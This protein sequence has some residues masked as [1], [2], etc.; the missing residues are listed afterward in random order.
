MDA[1]TLRRAGADALAFLLPIQCA[2]CG[3]P[4]V[5]LCED[6]AAAV[7]PRPLER[8]V[9]GVRVVSGLV[10]EDRVARIVRVLK[11]EGR[12]SLARALAP[13]LAAAARRFDDVEFTVVPVPTSAAAMR[14][15]GY[16]VAELLARRAGWH[17]QRLLRVVRRT[18]DQRALGR[19]ERQGNVAESMRSRGAAAGRSILLVDDVVTTGAT[20][21]EAMRALRAAGAEVVGAVTVAATPRRVPTRT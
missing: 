12:T 9:D 7:R 14:R 4:D 10:F 8:D 16:R 21:G 2:G 18:T 1:E 6:C 17:P 19:A 11:E 15:R 13:A 20:L 5:S 3:E